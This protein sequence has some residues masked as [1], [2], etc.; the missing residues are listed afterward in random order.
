MAA[1]NK[2]TDLALLKVEAKGLKAVKFALNTKKVPRGNWFRRGRAGLGDPVA[3][4][5]VS[6]M[7]RKLTGRDTVVTNPNRGYLGVI[8]V[9][10]KDAE[11]IAS[12]ERSS[13]RWLPVA[14]RPPRRG[15]R[16]ATSSSR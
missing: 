5:I 7:T 9:D 3:V 12:S 8:P 11:G 1:G 15:C 6:V 13:R 16:R 2:G 10:D 4:G 14:Q